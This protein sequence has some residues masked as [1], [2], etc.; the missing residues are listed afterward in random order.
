MMYTTH[1]KNKNYFAGFVF[2]IHYLL[3]TDIY[4]QNNIRFADTQLNHR[5]CYT[6]LML[7]SVYKL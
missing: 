5:K 2:I 7:T 6:G 3:A 4:M 1:L